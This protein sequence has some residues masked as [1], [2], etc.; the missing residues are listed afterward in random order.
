M[1]IDH[2][3]QNLYRIRKSRDLNM[4]SLAGMIGLSR[5]AYSNLENGKSQ[6][7]SSTLAALSK[8]LQIDIG[9]LLAVPPEFSSLRFRS[10]N[11]LN[12]TQ[13]NMRNQLL[14]DVHRWLKDYNEL[15]LL[16]GYPRPRQLKVRSSDPVKA[17]A[18]FRKFMNLDEDEPVLDIIGLLE[19]HGVKFYLKES[20][21]DKFFGFSIGTA[22]GGPAIVVNTE[23]GISIERHIFTVAHELSHLLLHR[24]SFKPDEVSEI[25][26]EEKEA[27]R[28]AG[29]FLLPEC[30]FNRELKESKGL[31]WIDAVLHIK[32]KFRVSYKTILHRIIETEGIPAKDLYPEFSLEIK[33]RYGIS[34]KNHYEP[35]PIEEEIGREP[36]PLDSNDFVEDKLSRLVREAYEKEELS[37]SRAA[38]ILRLSLPAMRNLVD[39]WKL[40]A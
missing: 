36:V 3:P 28:F 2:L 9:D 35:Y 38:E 37:L 32:R 5:I 30:G 13:Q 22:D 21:L 24:S 25:D 17:A 29:H 40:C 18:E 11:I 33:K 7:K 20:K 26:T 27:D 31:H 4:E 8:A 39:N 1:A 15:S 14:Y 19:K 6:P 12:K 16:L 34:L 10:S 23:K